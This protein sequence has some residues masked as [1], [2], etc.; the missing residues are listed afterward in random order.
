MISVLQKRKRVA[1]PRCPTD[2]GDLGSPGQAGR[3]RS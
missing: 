3:W 1:P 2:R